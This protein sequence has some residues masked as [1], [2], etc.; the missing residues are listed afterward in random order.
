[1]K[2]VK[3]YVYL[4]E[5][6]VENEPYKAQVFRNRD[7]AYLWGTENAETYDEIRITE[8]KVR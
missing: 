7:K 5:I 6:W 4:C 1:M 2:E 3:E 8:Y